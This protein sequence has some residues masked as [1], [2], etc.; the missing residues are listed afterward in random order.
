MNNDNDLCFKLNTGNI[1]TTF[2]EVKEKIIC[3]YKN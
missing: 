1:F 2:Y 3:K